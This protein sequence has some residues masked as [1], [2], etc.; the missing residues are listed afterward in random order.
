MMD[1]L[2][3][4]TRWSTFKYFVFLIVSTYYIGRVAQSV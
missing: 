2:R 4:E 1:P 3:S